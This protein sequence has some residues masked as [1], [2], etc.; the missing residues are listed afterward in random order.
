M[1]FLWL[2]DSTGWIFGPAILLAGV[3][4]L[5]MC[6]RESVGATTV[7]RRRA[8]LAWSLLPF[9]LGIAAALVGAALWLAG[10]MPEVTTSN[11]ARRL[12]KACLAGLITTTPPLAWAVAL[13]RRRRAS[14]GAGVN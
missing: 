5:A 9:V 14:Q 10:T 12:G 13:V 3:L 4:A 7:K 1:W 11:A 8:A 6:L 2:F